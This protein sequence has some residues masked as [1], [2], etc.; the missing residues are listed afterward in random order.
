MILAQ[1]SCAEHAQRPEGANLSVGLGLRQFFIDLN[2][3]LWTKF[4]LFTRTKLRCAVWVIIQHSNVTIGFAF[5]NYYPHS[6]HMLLFS[7]RDTK[8]QL[9]QLA[10]K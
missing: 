8:Y 9:H 7:E 3:M 4:N 6:F 1:A 2:N 10:R 5:F